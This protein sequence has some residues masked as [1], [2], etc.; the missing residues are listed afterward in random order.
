MFLINKITVTI[1]YSG[2]K[3]NHNFDEITYPRHA[4]LPPVR[5]SLRV[6]LTECQL[7]SL[8]INT[9]YEVNLQSR[10]FMFTVYYISGS[11]LRRTTAHN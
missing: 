4:P 8:L 9:S 6:V 11:G 10:R 1:K 3:L 5:D 2:R 7:S